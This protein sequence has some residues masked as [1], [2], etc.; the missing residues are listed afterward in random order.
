MRFDIPRRRLYDKA[1]MSPASEKAA[2]GRAFLAAALLALLA[3]GCA[4]APA[5]PAPDGPAPA[6]AASS[7]FDPAAVSAEVKTAA[8]ADIK[9]LIQGLNTI[10]QRKDYESWLGYLTEDYKQHYSDPAV[11]AQ[12]SEYPVLKRAGIK[13]SSLKDYFLY[14][15]YPSRQNDR[16][17]DIEY[18]GEGL[19]K[20]ITVSPKGDRQI[21]YNL[22]KHGDTWKIGIGR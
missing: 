14:V 17:D 18:L 19:V 11:L 13:L 7:S 20:A 8:I 9:A 6:P 1:M 4:S 2:S 10:I 5:S 21:L 15:V 12:I 3:A 16:V 22:E